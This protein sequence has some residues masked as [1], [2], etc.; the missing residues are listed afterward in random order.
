MHVIYKLYIKGF[1]NKLTKHEKIK[2]FDAKVGLI[3]PP[4]LYN[5]MKQKTKLPQR[6]YIICGRFL[7]KYH[8]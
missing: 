4:T 6:H 8:K 7:N 5:A 1:Y 2:K 3:L